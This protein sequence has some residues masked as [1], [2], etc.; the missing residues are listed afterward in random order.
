MPA[1][2]RDSGSDLIL[3]ERRQ[4]VVGDKQTWTQSPHDRVKRGP[5]ARGLPGTTVNDEIFGP[6]GHVRIE[7]VV[8]HPQ[9]SFLR[10][11]LAGDLGTARRADDIGH[12]SKRSTRASNGGR[13]IF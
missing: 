9:R 5:V 11:A 2:M 8:E 1:F 4:D 10:P 7:I 12:G 3:V 13:F 6:L